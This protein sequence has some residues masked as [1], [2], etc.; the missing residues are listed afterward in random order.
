M[1]IEQTL[2]TKLLSIAKVYPLSLPENPTLP[3]ITYQRISTSPQRNHSKNNFDR[4]RF[5]INIWSHLY[6]EVIDKAGLV[7][8]ALDLN[9]T[10][11][12]FGYKNNQF[13]VKE[14]DTGLFGTVL[15]FFIDN[16]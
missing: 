2:V 5:Q 8:T 4:M 10:D 15:E 11:F 9:T 12:I 7:V 14:N 6:D 13:E 3:A 1:T 16:D